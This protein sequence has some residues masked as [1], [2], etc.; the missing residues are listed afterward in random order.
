MVKIA[1]RECLI[2]DGNGS[3]YRSKLDG[4]N[5]SRFKSIQPIQIWEIDA[6]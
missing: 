4:L 1:Y 5:S 6:L 3:Q 2:S